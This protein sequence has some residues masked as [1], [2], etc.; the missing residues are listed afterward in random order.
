MGMQN[1]KDAFVRQRGMAIIVLIVVSLLGWDRMGLRLSEAR[2]YR[3]ITMATP[4][5]SVVV[6]HESLTPEGALLRG[7]MVKRRC[8]FQFLSGYV[9]F[10]NSVRT[11]AHINTDFEP[12]AGNRPPNPHDQLWGPW[13]LEYSGATTPVTWEIYAHHKCPEG[14]FAQANLFA[15]GEWPKEIQ[16]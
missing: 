8:E 16:P 13:L 10:E 7:S 15:R 14:T 1:T 2:W 3:D 12:I 11:R 4:F 9:G 6:T 5:H